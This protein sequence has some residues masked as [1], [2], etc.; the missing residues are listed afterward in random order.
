[1]IWSPSVLY[2]AVDSYGILKCKHGK[3]GGGCLILYKLM[4][5][6]ATFAKML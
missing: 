6:S 1:M 5:T 2:H 3:Q 4:M